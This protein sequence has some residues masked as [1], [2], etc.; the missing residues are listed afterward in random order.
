MNVPV[1][2]LMAD[3]GGPQGAV[4]GEARL[5]SGSAIGANPAS[6]EGLID[7]KPSVWYPGAG[8][9][10]PIAVAVNVSKPVRSIALEAVEFTKA[11]QPRVT[12]PAPNTE[13]PIQ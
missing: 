5:L 2:K 9:A 6:I 4:G 10:T 8:A 13:L 3:V 7:P 12:F 11:A 1:P